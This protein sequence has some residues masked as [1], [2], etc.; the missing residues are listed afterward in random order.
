MKVFNCLA[1]T[2]NNPD[3]I[4]HMISDHQK[5]VKRDLDR[6]NKEYLNIFWCTYYIR[7]S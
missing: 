3:S 6:K 7:A 2:P 1:N 4:Y 5:G